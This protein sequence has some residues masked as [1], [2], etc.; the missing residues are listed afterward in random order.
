MQ[1]VILAA[2]MGARLRPLTQTTPKPLIDLCGKPL[3]EYGLE[4]L[5]PQIDE[6]F[7]VVN[8]LSEQIIDRLGAHWG[9]IPIRYV[10]QDPLSGT[11]G[12]VHLLRNHVQGNFLVMNS[13]DVYVREDLDELVQHPMAL[14]YKQTDKPKTSGALVEHGRFMGLGASTNAVCGAYVLNEQFFSIAPVEIQVSAHREL[15]LP[16]TLAQLTRDTHITAVQAQS[17]FAV[18]THDQLA[19]AIHHFSGQVCG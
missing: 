5:P 16:Q 15:G 2:G 4:A 14:L 3:I 11:G 1:A 10:I 7:I 8:Y 6:I 19:Q 9:E 13:D 18:G 12:A 17:W